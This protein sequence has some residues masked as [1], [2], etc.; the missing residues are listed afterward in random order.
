LREIA[1]LRPRTNVIGCITRIRSALSILTHHYFQNIGFIYINT[2]IITKIDC[3]GI[4]ELFSVTTLL[5]KFDK[6]NPIDFKTDF[7]KDQVFLTCSGQLELEAYAHAFSDVYAFGPVFN[8]E[9]GHTAKTAN[10]YWYLEPEL[11]TY[12]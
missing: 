6:Q 4:S 10:E 5:D 1:H 7:F 2:P 8:A 11:C 9:R 3:E 12:N